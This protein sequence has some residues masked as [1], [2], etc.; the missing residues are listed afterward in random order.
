MIGNSSRLQSFNLKSAYPFDKI[1]QQTEQ[2]QLA[3]SYFGKQILASSIR[4]GQ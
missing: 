3:V 4:H 1:L 2:L